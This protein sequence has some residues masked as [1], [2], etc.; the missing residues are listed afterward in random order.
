MMERKYQFQ[1]YYALLKKYI[2][3]IKKGNPP[4]TKND[5]WWIF[6]QKT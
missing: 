4:F 6:L 3:V 1:I 5:K 2:I